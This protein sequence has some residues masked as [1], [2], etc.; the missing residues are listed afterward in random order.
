MKK[1]VHLYI[2]GRVQGVFFRDYMRD[3]ARKVGATGWVRNLPDGRVEAVVE[4]EADAV[5]A[6]V[7]WCYRGSPASRVDNVEI[8]ED[9]YSGEFSDFQIRY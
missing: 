7:N 3:T 5:N 1:R 2:S 8:S 4:G 9:I 6:V